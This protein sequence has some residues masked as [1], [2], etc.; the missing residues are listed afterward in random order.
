MRKP[1]ATS[2]DHAITAMLDAAKGPPPVPKHV[3]LRN[4]DQPFWDGVIRA[5]AYSEWTQ[6]DL[7]VAAQLAR[8][9]ADIER[10]QSLLDEEGTTIENARGTIVANARVSVLE[11]L[12][13]RELALMRSLRITG[14]AALGDTRDMAAK[15]KVQRESEA[16]REEIEDDDLIAR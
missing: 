9:Q 10:E 1:R 14:A 16:I 8:T 5:R 4:G 6:C 2:N 12:A 3:K 13:R 15:R 11:N 7:V